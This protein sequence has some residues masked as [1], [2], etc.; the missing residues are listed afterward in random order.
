MCIVLFCIRLCYSLL[1]LMSLF[2][3]VYKPFQVIQRNILLFD[4][5]WNSTQIW[6]IEILADYIP[7]CPFTKIFF[8]DNG[9]VLIT[10]WNEASVPHRKPT[11]LSQTKGLSPR[12]TP[13]IPLLLLLILSYLQHCLL[14]ITRS[15]SS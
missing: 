13:S 3:L 14:Q 9:I 4:Q 6:I 5:R 1:F 12:N 11:F 10:Y 8:A 7:Q 15:F 2:H